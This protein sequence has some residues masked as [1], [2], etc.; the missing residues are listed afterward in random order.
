MLSVVTIRSDRY[1][2]YPFRVDHGIDRSFVHALQSST[3][4]NL[5]LKSVPIVRFRKLVVSRVK[6]IGHDL[7]TD[8]TTC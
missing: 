5:L 4:Q 3:I 7:C 6:S 1:V 2:K 8:G